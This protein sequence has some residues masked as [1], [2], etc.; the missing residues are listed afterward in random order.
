MRIDAGGRHLIPGLWDMHVHALWDPIVTT[1]VLPLM[2]TQG[3]TGMRDMR[4]HAGGRC[5]R[6]GRDRAR[7][8]CGRRAS[9]R[10][11]A[12]LDGPEPVD[13]S[14]SLA[15]GRPPMRAAAVATAAARV[16]F[17][18]VY[19][20]LPAPAFRA[21]IQE[22]ARQGLRVRGHVPGAVTP[23]EAAAAGMWSI[24]HMRTELGGYCTRAT[25]AACG[26]IL[27]C[28]PRP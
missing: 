11:V 7:A 21:V 3:V 20:L 2:L 8:R 6:C 12:I 16:D 9:S 27:A 17:I 1:T 22:A 18:K 13:P 19:T 24:E 5:G 15:I 23:M 28:I 25:A 14:V 10:R 4:R 26:P